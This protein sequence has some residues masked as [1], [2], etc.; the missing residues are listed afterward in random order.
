MNTEFRKIDSGIDLII[1]VYLDT[2]VLL[3][4]LSSIADGFAVVEKITTQDVTKNTKE[5]TMGTEFGIANILNLLKINLSASMEKQQ[6]KESKEERSLERYYTYGSLLY[7]LRSNLIKSN[8]VKPFSNN[9]KWSEVKS[10]DIIEIK[11]TFCYNPLAEAFLSIERL[12]ELLHSGISQ[13]QKFTVGDKH[14][15]KE[16]YNLIDALSNFISSLHSSLEPGDI[17]TFIVQIADNSGYKAIVTLFKEYLRDKTMRELINGEF[18]VLGKVVKN[19][20]KEPI[21]LLKGTGFSILGD[22]FIKQ[23]IDGFSQLEEKGF[24]IP[25]IKRKIDPPILQILPI[26]VYI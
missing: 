19:V 20:D 16:N 15:A 13:V 21:D 12:I 23:L 26:A 10:A 25:E 1:P 2:N 6:T 11:G 18:R 14:K 4:L 17:Y 24:S 8:L 3:D 7:K 5:G 9:I 22:D